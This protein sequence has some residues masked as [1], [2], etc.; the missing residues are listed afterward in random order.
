MSYCRNRK[1]IGNIHLRSDIL[2]TTYTC[3]K[4]TQGILL[5]TK[6]CYWHI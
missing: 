2:S 4:V 3:S 5:E 6:P 1:E